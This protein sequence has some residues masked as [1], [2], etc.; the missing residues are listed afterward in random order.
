[1][2]AVVLSHDTAEE[3]VFNYANLAAQRRFDMDWES[4]TALPSKQSAEPMLQEERQRLIETVRQQGYI[5]DYSGVRISAAGQRFFIPRATV[6]NLLDEQ[7][8]YHGQAAVF[9]EWQDL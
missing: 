4:L 2:D 3:P 1:M 5:D 7:G 9:T 6:W 8:G